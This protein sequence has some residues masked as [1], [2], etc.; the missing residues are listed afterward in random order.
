[1]TTHKKEYATLSRF[2]T[3]FPQKGDT[4]V[5]RIMAEAEGYAMVRRLGCVP[6][7]CEIK[8]LH[9]RKDKP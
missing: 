3:M 8:Q 2:K 1:M 5:V 4:F 9:D 6:F 7:I